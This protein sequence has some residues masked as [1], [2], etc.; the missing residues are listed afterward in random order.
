MKICGICSSPIVQKPNESS[1]YFVKKKYCS[2][3]CRNESYRNKPSSNRGKHWVIGPEGRARMRASRKL[4]ANHWNW[5]GGITPVNKLIRNS[6][7]ANE[8]R[9][10]V[11]E[12]DDYTCQHCGLSKEVSGNLNA[13]HIKP[14]A[15]YPELRFELSNG[16]TLCKPCHLKT[17]THGGQ[18]IYRHLWLNNLSAH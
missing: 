12:R 15:L 3:S 14:F 7:E 13:D 4:G 6:V 9:K 10:A 16:R 8:W 18:L 17:D 2:F 11:F 5:K 1:N